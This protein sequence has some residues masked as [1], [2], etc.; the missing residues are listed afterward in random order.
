[1]GE[2]GDHGAPAFIGEAFLGGLRNLEDLR[3]DLERPLLLAGQVEA[4]M[5]HL[6]ADQLIGD[7]LVNLGAAQA[8]YP[9]LRENAILPAPGMDNTAVE[10]R[11]ES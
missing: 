11:R 1:M 9:R 6:G 2:H 7:P 5:Q 10:D 3:A 8:V 4:R